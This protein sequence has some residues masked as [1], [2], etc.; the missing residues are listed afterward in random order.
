MEYEAIRREVL[1]TAQALATNGLTVGDSGNVSGRVADPDRLLL[2]ITPH[3]R[4]Y[5]LL[6][7]EDIVVVDEEG[8]PIA[9][10]GIPSAELLLHAAVYR[11]R[12]DA[13]A[14][15]HAHPPLA[16][17][18]AVV[19]QPIPPILED[20]MIFLGGQIEVA[21]HAM[22]G[23]PELVGRALAALGDR[24]ACL[25][26]NHGALSVG[27]DLRAALHACQY[28]E[29]V[30]Q[31]FLYATWAGQVNVLPPEVVKVETAFFKMRR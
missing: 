6:T 16:S 25:L 10:D 14:V 30:A 21:P 20:Q 3:G 12:P 5:D 2:A 18:A 9:G 1:L 13:G 15:I 29:K 11:A 27:R 31:A 17:A 22:T 4:Y 26:A 28:L 7:P 23:S 24:N 19:G 8:E